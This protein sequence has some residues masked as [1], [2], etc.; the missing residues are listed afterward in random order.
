M[1]TIAHYTSDGKCISCIIFH[2]VDSLMQ[3]PW[4]IKWFSIFLRHFCRDLDICC[5]MIHGRMN[6]P[7]ILEFFCLFF[8]RFPKTMPI[9]DL[10][11]PTLMTDV[12]MRMWGQMMPKRGLL[13]YTTR[14]S[15]HTTTL[16]ASE[17]DYAFILLSFP[18]TIMDCR[19]CPNICSTLDEPANDRG[20]LMISLN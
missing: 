11:P 17:D 13:E 10:H 6:F 1:I 3:A 5:A 9:F 2:Y 14:I 7:F 4:C 12:W 19:K 15:T 16:L 20:I 8:E 18:Y